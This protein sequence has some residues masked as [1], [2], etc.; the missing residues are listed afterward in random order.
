M[1]FIKV[2]ATSHF[3]FNNLPYGI[4]STTNNVGGLYFF[5]ILKLDGVGAIAVMSETLRPDP[6]LIGG[7]NISNPLINCLCFLV[8][9][10][11]MI[12][13]SFNQSIILTSIA[14]T[15]NIRSGGAE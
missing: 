7:G 14:A 9:E 13:Q 11:E 15:S 10:L 5:N 2:N 12:G 4:F 3:S 8:V 1:S 6:R